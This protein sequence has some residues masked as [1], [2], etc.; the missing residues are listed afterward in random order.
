ML[1]NKINYIP[2]NRNTQIPKI[3][4]N[5]TVLFWFCIL[6][7]ETKNIEHHGFS[8]GI[9]QLLKQNRPNPQYPYY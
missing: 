1:K 5:R 3:P 6:K 2:K 4:K 8:F 7:I 9:G